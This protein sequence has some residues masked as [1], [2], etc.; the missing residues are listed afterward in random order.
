MCHERDID[1]KL[2]FNIMARRKCFSYFRGS[3]LPSFVSL[4][5]ADATC[6]FFT[7]TVCLQIHARRVN[8]ISIPYSVLAFLSRKLNCV[9]VYGTVQA[10]LISEYQLF[11]QLGDIIESLIE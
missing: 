1:T 7:F 3:I 9:K 10:Y 11:K 4:F 6:L 5:V 8:F 2:K